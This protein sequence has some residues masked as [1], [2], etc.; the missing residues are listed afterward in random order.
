MAT[1]HD[2]QEAT[3]RREVE[4]LVGPNL[5]PYMHAEEKF[6]SMLKQH[7]REKSNGT[8][9]D[10]GEGG[11]LGKY[12]KQLQARREF[13]ALHTGRPHKRI[14]SKGEQCGTETTLHVSNVADAAEEVKKPRL[15]VDTGLRERATGT[16]TETKVVGKK[17]MK[18]HPKELQEPDCTQNG[19]QILVQMHLCGSNCDHATVPTL[20]SLARKT[21]STMMRN[22][23]DEQSFANVIDSLSLID[24]LWDVDIDNIAITLSSMHY[25]SLAP[26][27]TFD[28]LLA[29]KR[30]SG[31]TPLWAMELD[32]ESA[33][34]APTKLPELPH[35]CTSSKSIFTLYEL[36]NQFIR[37]PVQGLRHALK[38][39]W[40]SKLKHMH[41]AFVQ[42]GDEEQRRILSVQYANLLADSS[43]GSS[44]GQGAFRKRI[45]YPEHVH[46]DAN[47]WGNDLMY[48][49][50]ACLVGVNVWVYQSQ[51]GWSYSAPD[52]KAPRKHPL[53]KHELDEKYA[54]LPIRIGTIVPTRGD[55]RCFFHA[56]V[57]CCQAHRFSTGKWT[58]MKTKNTSEWVHPRMDIV[59]FSHR[60]H[61]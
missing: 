2:T 1:V 25:S 43:K 39:L 60:L 54:R 47:S 59:S 61:A 12:K 22:V 15:G 27:E 35:Y 57:K 17:T 42:S 31:P 38:M 50:V 46:I 14:L 6:R 10:E 37:S 8:S 56:V 16:D 40:W 24:N 4:G 11:I 9:N 32:G 41:T 5:V 36:H 51:A 55:G 33:T 7:Q 19:L 18:S 48:P 30:T 44:L 26:D 52:E 28:L 21:V 53:L 3:A 45:M 29:E 34:L 20:F 13:P 49:L 23:K 58:V